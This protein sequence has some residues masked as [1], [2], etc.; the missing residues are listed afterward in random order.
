MFPAINKYNFFGL[1]WFLATLLLLQLSGNRFLEL[2][3]GV[4]AQPL[5]IVRAVLNFSLVF[6]VFFGCI[7]MGRRLLERLGLHAPDIMALGVGF[8]VLNAAVLPLFFLG[9]LKLPVLLPFFAVFLTTTIGFK[10]F[11]TVNFFIATCFK[12][13]QR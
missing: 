4:F 11:T 7:G 1:S 3:A 10:G 9:L 6:S 5:N 8:I 13:I 2:S 12:L